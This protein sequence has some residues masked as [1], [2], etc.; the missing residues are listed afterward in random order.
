[1]EQRAQEAEEFY[2]NE[3]ENETNEEPQADENA[4]D[5]NDVPPDVNKEENLSNAAMA[6]SVVENDTELNLVTDDICSDDMVTE[7]PKAEDGVEVEM[8]PTEIDEK[9]SEVTE[10][11]RQSSKSPK[12]EVKLHTEITDLDLELDRLVERC[13]TKKKKLL[14]SDNMI[15]DLETNEMIPKDKSGADE[16]LKRLCKNNENKTKSNVAA[17]NLRYF[18]AFINEF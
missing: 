17:T 8:V 2:R 16:L 1:M 14:G 13:G 3:N 18:I 4:R 12:N 7:T 15:I 5:S 9:A 10:E 11:I 6:E